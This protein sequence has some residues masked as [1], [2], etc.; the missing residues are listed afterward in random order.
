MRL[1]GIIGRY[2]TQVRV[3]IT[4]TGVDV[5][6]RDFQHALA[7]RLITREGARVVRAERV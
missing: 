3:S 4:K 7:H 1:G 2:E 5:P 6:L